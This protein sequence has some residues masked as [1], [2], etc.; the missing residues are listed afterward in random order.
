MRTPLGADR[1]VPVRSLSLLAAV[2]TQ[3]FGLGCHDLLQ[4]IDDL[5][6]ASV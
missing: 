5:G 1:L 6:A 4:F 2:D 3:E